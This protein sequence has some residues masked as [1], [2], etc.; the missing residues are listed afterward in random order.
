MLEKYAKIMIQIKELE[1]LA[2]E[3]KPQV[4]EEVLSKDDQK[5]ET[6]YGKF[7]IMKRKTWT[8]PEEVKTKEQEY[9]VAKAKAESEETATY[10]VNETLIFK[11]IEL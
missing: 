11:A 3:I 5:A 7:S 2:E 9:K 1:S 4:L 10:T 6:L 8:Y